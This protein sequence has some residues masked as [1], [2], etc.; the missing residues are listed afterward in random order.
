M[1]QYR[2]P[3]SHKTNKKGALNFWLDLG[4]QQRYGPLHACKV[5]Q[6]LGE[7]IG[8]DV[9]SNR[10][11]SVSIVVPLYNEED[12]VEELHQRLKAV[13]DATGRRYELVF[14]NDG[15][16]DGTLAKLSAIQ[17]DDPAVKLVDLAGNSGQTPAL[18]AGF[19]HAV[20]DVVIP[21]DGDLQHLPEEIPLFLE[22]I[23]EGY[24]VVSGWRQKRKESYLIRLVPSLVANKAMSLVSG[25]PLHDFGTTYKAYRR[26]ILDRICLYGQFHRFIPVLAKP[27]KARMCEIPIAAPARETGQSKYGF[28]RTY[29]V[30]FDIMRI[31]FLTSF[32]SN[33]LQFFGALGFVLVAFGGIMSV[34]LMKDKYLNQMEIMQDRGP[35]FIATV[36]LLMAGLQMF[37][38]GFL[39][40]MMT[41]FH[42]ETGHAKLY[43]VRSVAGKGLADANV[44]Q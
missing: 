19:D 25:I 4:K 12:C 20:G 15:S 43:S 39:G 26:E 14:V 2:R 33:P 28:S 3:V 44:G 40:E 17:R 18:A 23:D 30:L 21:M 11:D 16:S 13:M 31:K 29:T 7:S 32:I 34:V 36:F 22:K 10:E 38:I 27:L 24:Q 42:H 1:A 9:V 8:R 5:R 6:P 37:S 35:F 41:R